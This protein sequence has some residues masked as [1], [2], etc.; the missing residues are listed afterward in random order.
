M[1]EQLVAAWRRPRR[2]PSAGQPYT[3]RRVRSSSRT[4]PGSRAGPTSPRSSGAPPSGSARTASRTP[5]AARARWAT[6]STSASTPT[7]SATRPSA[8]TMSMLV[9]PQM[10]NTMVPASHDRGRRR[11]LAHRGV[12]RRP[13]P[14]LH[15]AGLHR[16]SHGLAQPPVRHPRLAARAR[17]V[18]RRGPHPPLPHQG[19]RRAAAHLPAVLRAL[20][21]DGPGRQL[22]PA[23]RQAEARPQAGRPAGPDD[24]LP[25]RAPRRAR[26]GRLRRRRRQPALAAPRGLP[27]RGCSRSTT[28]ATSGWPPRP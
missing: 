15:A 22:H 11:R 14:P 9:P 12:L 23:G 17:H 4:G 10:I 16:P 8:A 25:A 5:A 26:R 7:S 24:R 20:H 18:G 19:A 6:C 13:D 2:P 3:Y 21:P 28:S 1:T 27:R